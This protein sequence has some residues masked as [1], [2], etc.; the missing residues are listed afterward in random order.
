VPTRNADLAG[1]SQSPA[2]AVE[3]PR[4]AEN[5]LGN[6]SRVPDT[7]RA[8]SQPG[9]GPAAPP[10]AVAVGQAAALPQERRKVRLLD[11]ITGLGKS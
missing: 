3:K 6:V 10:Q 1:Q 5:G 2:D 4:G 9:A 11:R 8:H 7:A